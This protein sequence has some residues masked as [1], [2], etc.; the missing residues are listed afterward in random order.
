MKRLAIGWGTIRVRLLAGFAAILLLLA[1]AGIVGRLSLTSLSDR[2]AKSLASVRRESQLTAA[3]TAS[4]SQ[5]L[6]AGARY[7]EQPD[8][9]TENAFRDF[10][11]KTH[12]AQRELNASP[13]MESADIS[14]IAAIDQQL[15]KLENELAAAHRLKDLHRDAEALATASV[16]PLEAALLADLRQLGQRRARQM[17]LTA[18]ALHADAQQRSGILLSVIFGAMLLGVLIVVSTIRSIVGP[19]GQLR[20]QARALSTGRLDVRTTAELPGEFQ[21]LATTMNSTSDWLARVVNIAT[22][23]ADEVSMSAH[24]LASAA[25]QISMA[26]GQTAT[27]MSGV[28]EGATEQ[29]HALRSVDDS[30]HVMRGRADAVRTGASEVRVLAEGIEHSARE[31]RVE[32]DR[33]L[34]ILKDVRLSVERAAAEVRQLDTT[35]VSINRFVATVSRIAEQ[36]NLLALNAA[37]EA[38]RAGVAGRG[39]AVVADEVRKLAEQAQAAADD[40]VQLTGAVTAS[41]ASTAQAMH[42]S[43]AR[44]GE[45][46]KLSHDIDAALSDIT[47]AAERTLIAASDVTVAADENV[48]AVLDASSGISQAARTAESHAAAAEQVSAS[49]QEQSAACE[50]MSAASATL[51]AGASRLKEIVS[52]LRAKG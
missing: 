42:A 47:R 29:A 23:T 13:G 26:A 11:R 46:E 43:S 44:V 6:A 21:E 39:F 22:G 24:E 45:I 9:A 34:G 19:L 12:Q 31:K 15:S 37:I 36:T 38:A 50:Q 28:T 18:A 5:E 27:A 1:A 20:A 51:L 7:L 3:I 33:S 17:D 4:A 8:S 40:V 16:R 49:T 2:I 32:V 10:G 30:L 48:S 25:D 41:V 35:A 14:L 52:E